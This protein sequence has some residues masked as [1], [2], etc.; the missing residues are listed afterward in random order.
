ML[1]RILNT[2]ADTFIPREREHFFKLSFSTSPNRSSEGTTVAHMI[3]DLGK[4]PKNTML[5]KTIFK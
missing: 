5:R 2:I 3:E 4:A 1:S